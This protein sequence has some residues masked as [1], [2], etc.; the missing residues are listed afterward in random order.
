MNSL[1]EYAASLCESAGLQTKGGQVF[2][3]ILSKNDDAGRHGVLVPIEA[4][5]FFP[6][7][8]IV[9][10]AKNATTEFLSFDAVNKTQRTIAFKYYERYPE[11]RLTRLNQ[12][13]SRPE[14]GKR[15]QVT[16]RAELSD[17]NIVFI[18]DAATEFGDGRLDV[19]WKLIAGP[20]IASDPG[21]YIVAPIR[22]QG[23]VVD[24]PLSNLLVKF[25]AIQGQWFD[26]L[27][28][29][30]TG[31]GYTF[32]TLLGIKE[33][34]DKVADFQGI[35]LKC[36]QK[37]VNGSAGGKINLF[38]Q[39]PVWAKKLSAPDRIREFGQL[40]SDGLYACYSQVTTTPNNLKLALLASLDGDRLDIEKAG[41]SVG[42]WLHKT[43]QKRLAEKHDRAAF[44]KA[45]V[46]H[47]KS[48]SRFKYDE[49]VYCEKP[50]ID[51]FLDLVARN[52]LVFEFL[53]SVRHNKFST[54]YSLVEN[55][56]K[57]LYPSGS[58]RIGS[59]RLSCCHLL[60]PCSFYL[61]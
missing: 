26:S 20:A 42:H 9:D 16:L 29:G 31:I 13:L 57:I 46:S 25:D 14:L 27:R 39:A 61:P 21:A 40:R 10:P 58:S 51:R 28:S 32:E 24:A 19:I 4:Y 48:G 38:Q 6:D 12:M 60:N 8:K 5:P 44:V 18:D 54:E 33:N 49:L 36:K 47:T 45:A 59:K 7:L 22:Y 56:K 55:S 17:G 52:Q 1:A 43:L 15:L 50:A 41:V 34:N 53:M 37:K 3:K 30:D 11:R 35:E 23:L 2:A